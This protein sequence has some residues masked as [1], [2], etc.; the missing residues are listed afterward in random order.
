MILQRRVLTA[1]DHDNIRYVHGS[2]DYLRYR[3]SG[4]AG[5]EIVATGHFVAVI[6]TVVSSFSFTK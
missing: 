6:L 3:P 2:V 4:E 5:R 1:E